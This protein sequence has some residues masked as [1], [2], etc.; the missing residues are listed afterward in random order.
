MEVLAD[1]LLLSSWLADPYCLSSAMN[2]AIFYFYYKDTNAIG[3]EP[4]PYDFI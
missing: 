1:W 3:L 4:R 2:A